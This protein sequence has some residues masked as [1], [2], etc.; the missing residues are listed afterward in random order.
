MKNAVKY[1]FDFIVIDD[2]SFI[3]HIEKAA[4]DGMTSNYDFI[5]LPLWNGLNLLV[6]K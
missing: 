4:R 2:T 5:S 6:K 3:P 1:G